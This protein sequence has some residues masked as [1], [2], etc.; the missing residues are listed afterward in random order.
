MIKRA[1]SED[2]LGCS[3]VFQCQKCFAQRRDSLEMM[4]ILVGQ[5]QSELNTVS[6]K[7]VRASHSQTVDEVA[8]AA[9]ISHGTCHRIL[10]DDL[11]MSHV[12]QRPD[13]RRMRLS[14]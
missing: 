6:K 12:T 9:G 7:L 13:A 2:A 8:V 4:S 11:N 14:L 10:S 3:A 5:E 1:Y